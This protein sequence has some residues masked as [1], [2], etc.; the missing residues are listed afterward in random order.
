[1]YYNLYK[2]TFF[3]CFLLTGIIQTNYSLVLQNVRRHM[4]GKYRCEASNTHG[5][6]TSN[7]IMLNIRYAPYCKFTTTCVH[8]YDYDYDYDYY[9]YRLAYGLSLF[10]AANLMCEVDAN[11]MPS[12][13]LWKFERETDI[14]T[15]RSYNFRYESG[16]ILM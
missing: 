13:F 15:F 10:E 1:M 6:G 11:P 8:Y 9:Y 3:F 4:S 2:Y 12:S 14:T 7:S 5:I 16:V